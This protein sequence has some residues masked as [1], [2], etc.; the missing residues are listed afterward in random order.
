M[1]EQL[2]AA[3]AREF[4]VPLPDERAAQV[5]AQLEGQITGRGGLTGEALEG[6]EPAIVFEPSWA[7]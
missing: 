3:L 5:A 1:N 4:G 2:V 6:V 7:E